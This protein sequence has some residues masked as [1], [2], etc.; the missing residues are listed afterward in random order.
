MQ[1][2][3]GETVVFGLG[4]NYVISVWISLTQYEPTPPQAWL[5]SPTGH[6]ERNN[7]KFVYGYCDSL[8]KVLHP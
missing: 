2:N 8:F 3:S 4:V 6:I 1:T 5:F 7:N